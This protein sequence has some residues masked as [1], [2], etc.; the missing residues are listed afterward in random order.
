MLAYALGRTLFG[1]TAGAVAAFALAVLAGV[2]ALAQQ[3]RPYTLAIAAVLLATLVLALALE[4]SSAWW[5]AYVPACALLAFTHPIALAVLPAHAV[6]AA[7]GL[8]GRRPALL[9]AGAAVALG[10]A[11]AA[12]L[13][14][15][16]VADR[17]DALDGS[18][19]LRAQELA[20]GLLRAGGWNAALIALAALG[21]G[22]LLAG[23]AEQPAWRAALVAGLVAGPLV[24]VL[25]SAAFLPVYPERALVA[26]APG[27]ALAA[28][29]GAAWLPH[30][31]AASAAVAAVVLLA[32]PA[33][34]LWYVRP[35]TEDWRSALAAVESRREPGETVLVVPERARA[36]AAYYAPSLRIVERARGEGAWVLVLGGSDRLAIRAARRRV[37]T[38]RYALLAQER[39]G[40]RLVLLHW[41]RP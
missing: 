19:G 34:V 30:R 32:V 12:P 11:A 24:A 6:A 33:L 16:A 31:V 7:L 14:L 15:A 17:A 40:S 22:V 13:G 20:T 23:R 10:A 26:C 9:R 38:P 35:A 41:V 21:L 2:V 37:R 29:A 8:R 3:A 36:P 39:Y 1:P 18:G 5:L 25:A 4:R 28:G 27:I